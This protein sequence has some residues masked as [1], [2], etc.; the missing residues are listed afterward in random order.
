MTNQ[1]V[2]LLLQMRKKGTTVSWVPVVR[3][4]SHQTV[5][6][7]AA[8]SPGSQILYRGNN[9]GCKELGNFPK[10][11][12][13]VSSRSGFQVLSLRPFCPICDGSP[14]RQ[15][16]LGSF[17]YHLFKKAV[18]KFLRTRPA[19]HILFPSPSNGKSSF[20]YNCRLYQTRSLSDCNEYSPPYQLALD[21]TCSMSEK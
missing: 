4:L 1:V 16:T 18:W 3:L 6:H 8:I 13:M 17:R 20:M 10:G 7:T 15:T 11:T 21:L 9:K 19:Q 2:V 12:H 14:R 5:T